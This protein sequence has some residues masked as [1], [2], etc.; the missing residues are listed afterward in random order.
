MHWRK[1]NLL[2]LLVLITLPLL[3]Y[4][5]SWSPSTVTG[6]RFSLSLP[7]EVG[8]L[9]VLLFGTARM[10]WCGEA[11]RF[12]KAILAPSGLVVLS[13]LLAVRCSQQ[14]FWSVGILAAC[15]SNVAIL[16][17][18]SQFP[19]PRLSTLA[20][21]WL[22]TATIVAVNGLL[23][24]GHDEML[25]T[26]GNR[27]FLGAY[28]AASVLIG[29]GLWNWRATLC[30][31]VL[32]LALVFT[33]SRGAWVALGLMGIG[34]LVLS[35]TRGQI[36]KSAMAI[37][38][39]AT[40]AWF[41]RGYIV[42]EWQTDVR[43]LIW[44]GTLAMSRSRWLFGHGLGTFAFNYPR[45]RPPEYFRLPKAANLTD[46]AHN[47]LLETL[48]EQGAVGLVATI[49]LWVAAL[50]LGW[51]RLRQP[52]AQAR[53]R[54][55]LLAATV[56]LMLHGMV[57][58]D[59]RHPPNQ[60]LLWLLM[61][62]ISSGGTDD[63]EMRFALHDPLVR[64]TL[65]A[66]CVAVAVVV[67]WFFVVPQVRADYW[68]RRARIESE[69]GRLLEAAEDAD[70]A[71]AIQPLRVSARYLLAGILAETPTRQARSRALDE[72][73][74]LEALAPDYGDITFNLGQLLVAEQ[75]P[76]EALEYLQRAIQMNPYNASKRVVL[77]F[78]LGE[79]GQL[80]AA[81]AQLQQA[82]TLDPG[83]EK[84]SALLSEYERRSQ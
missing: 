9:V 23:R 14:P 30:C 16:L 40:T 15:A 65:A 57:D 3:A 31:A 29:V 2:C 41:E 75:R 34:W 8:V 71:L 77:G 80:V 72:A 59:L 52:N 19:E 35:G 33:R 17:L 53:L 54:A 21:A 63:Q 56:L 26:V 24:L 50:R 73:Q 84:A 38:I 69:R 47:E 70:R 7:I 45:F 74:R 55:G 67:G 32:V 13:W 4:P 60:T 44:R 46:H 20:W 66:V 43:P 64:R 25:S 5:L 27:N 39:I 76:G 18:S 22:A 49:W 61:G 62:I 11:L 68:E 81:R 79:L 36:W 58:V 42:Q 51:Q 10:L 37:L 82:L 12:P 48:A 6:Y 83:N 28:L 78:A 1:R